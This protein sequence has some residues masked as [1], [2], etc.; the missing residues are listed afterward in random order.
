MAKCSLYYTQVT[1]KK[2]HFEADI[3]CISLVNRLIKQGMD[4]TQLALT[5]VGWPNGEKLASTCV[6]IWSEPKWAQVIARQRKWTQGLAK[7]SRVKTQVFN[8]RLLRRVRLARALAFHRIHFHGIG[9]PLC[10]RIVFY[11]LNF[12]IRCCEEKA[13]KESALNGVRTREICDTGAVLYQMNHQANWEL[14]TFWYYALPL[15]F[16][17]ILKTAFQHLESLGITAHALENKICT[18]MQ[19][20]LPW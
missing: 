7:R 16:P 17:N 2:I 4:A 18:F 14:F 1:K 11:I 9:H 6:Q 20:F 13:W 5:W 15:S 3:S 8:L 12:H 10:V 19:A